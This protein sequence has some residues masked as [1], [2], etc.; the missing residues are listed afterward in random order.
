MWIYHKPNSYRCDSCDMI[1]D[2]CIP[3]GLR[4]IIDQ[5]ISGEILCV[6]NGSYSLG[7]NVI[8]ATDPNYPLGRLGSIPMPNGTNCINLIVSG[9]T[10][11][12]IHME[13][14]NG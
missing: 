4:N 9:D 8:Y 1:D 6:L 3:I 10:I 13:K 11:M 2:E 12:Y 14:T 7:I 5:H